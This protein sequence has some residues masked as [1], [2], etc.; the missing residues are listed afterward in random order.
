[1]AG[2][3]EHRDWERWT[4]LQLSKWLTNANP[5]AYKTGQME[6]TRFQASKAD[7]EYWELSAVIFL[8]LFDDAFGPAL[9]MVE[10][11]NK[12]EAWS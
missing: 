8:N 7:G 2:R 10:F 6:M 1:M 11:N 12:T 3:V 5:N 9:T 4:D